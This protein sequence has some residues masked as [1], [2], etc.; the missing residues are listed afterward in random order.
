MWIGEYKG[1]LAPVHW[2]RY[3]STGTLAPVH[4]YII[5]DF[6]SDKIDANNI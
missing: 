6:I 1:T 4:R 3:I 2:H 5:T